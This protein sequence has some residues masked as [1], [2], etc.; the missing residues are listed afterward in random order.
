MAT[1]VKA[2]KGLQPEAGVALAQD[3]NAPVQTVRVVK[4][5]DYK[6]HPVEGKSDFQG[7]M[8][9]FANTSAGAAKVV[10]ISARRL[11]S[12]AIEAGKQDEVF[13][14][15]EE[16]FEL[17]CFEIGIEGGNPIF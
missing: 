7:Y 11:L 12:A 14:E 2:I 8:M 15:T 9:E 6:N 17:I 10:P 5:I 13:S 4:T 1:K 16:G 3:V